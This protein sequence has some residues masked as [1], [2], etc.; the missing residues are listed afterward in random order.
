MTR[1][2][3]ILYGGTA[4][5]IALAIA[6]H[7]VRKWLVERGPCLH[8]KPRA[9]SMVPGHEG[10]CAS[11]WLN[12]SGLTARLD[13]GVTGFFRRVRRL[14]PVWYSYGPEFHA[15]APFGTDGTTVFTTATPDPY[16]DD[17]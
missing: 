10:P 7:F 16:Y 9:C 13:G 3:V 8:L 1:P 15:I 12:G 17:A 4:G 2:E 11:V 14:G 5:I 6:G